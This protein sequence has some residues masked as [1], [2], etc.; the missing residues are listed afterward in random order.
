MALFQ[1]DGVW[2]VR[3]TVHGQKY[4]ISTGVTDRRLAERRE[5][6]I[7]RE[8]WSGAFGWKE[9]KAPTFREWAEKYKQSYTVRK[10][11]PW[12][13]RQILAHALP[14]F[15]A[16][17]IDQV[18]RSDCH[19]YLAQRALTGISPWTVN[20]E[21]GLL[22][23]MWNAAMQDGLVNKNPWA[24]LKPMHAEPRTRVL[25]REESSAV[26]DVLGPAYR[27]FVLVALGTGL[28]LRELLGVTPEDVTPTELLVRSETAKGGK[29]RTVPLRA[30]VRQ[31]LRE[32]IEA[33]QVTPGQRLWPQTPWAVRKA[34]A[35]AGRRAKVAPFCIHD[36]RRTFATRA[37]SGGYPMS[38]LKDVLGHSSMETTSAYYVHTSRAERAQRL[39]AVDLGTDD[40]SSGTQKGTQSACPAA[41][42]KGIEGW[43][44]AEIDDTLG[45]LT[46]GSGRSAAW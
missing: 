3:K 5:A 36:L 10:R 33:R 7:V 34:L 42:G 12:R 21:H 25:T 29:S 2:Y 14:V 37:A 9:R 4:R 13:D 11:A 22:R 43:K 31:A 20:R 16:R 41:N 45:V 27:R 1:R 40:S 17:R 19:G 44:P 35:S 39:A 24:R 32:Q 38:M 23:A 15:G 30:E 8:L 26:L 28:R 46:V 18:T 6:E